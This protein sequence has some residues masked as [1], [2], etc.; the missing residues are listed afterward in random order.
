MN[1]VKIVTPAETEREVETMG[2]LR[3]SKTGNYYIRVKSGMRDYEKVIG[4]DKRAAEIA[5]AE[6][7]QELRIAKLTGQGWDG[8]A[9]MQKATKPRTF[10]EAVSDYIAERANYKASSIR[11]YKNIFDQHLLPK[12]RNKVLPDVNDSAVR[13]FQVELSAIRDGAKPLSARRINN[14]MQLLGS[15]L[16]QE[17]VRGHIQR[18]PAKAVKKLQETKPHIDPFTEEELAQ[19]I[20]CIDSH[21]QPFF[22]VFAYTGARPNELAALRWKDLSFTKQQITISKGLVRGAEGLPKTRAGQ[23]TIPMT[24]PVL[25]AL[26]Q[27]KDR[28]LVSPEYVFINKRGGPVDDHMDRVWKRAMKK[29]GLR[30]RASYQ[31]RHTFVSLCIVKGLPLQFIA[32]TI[33]HSTIDTLVRHYAAWMDGATAASN[34]KLKNAFD[35]RFLADLKAP[36][37]KRGSKGGSWGVDQPVQAP[38][39]H[40]YEHEWRRGWDSNPRGLRPSAFEAAPL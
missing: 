6:I 15:V 23:R 27:L 32:N 40:A 14:I 25:N 37:P 30:H 26:L 16:E 17:T 1:K 2:V 36:I 33:G 21:Y 31:L 20:R 39:D 5:L 13:R 35:G 12:F 24:P 38:Q 34:E 18:N 28:E 11:S 9:K 29:S 10:G 4:K 3:D 7:K 8:F 19:V 22:M